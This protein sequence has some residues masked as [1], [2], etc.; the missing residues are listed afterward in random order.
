MKRSMP[1]LDYAEDLVLTESRQ[2]DCH[3]PLPTRY[4]F[5]HP[6]WR[7]KGLA[8]TARLSLTLTGEQGVK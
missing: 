1:W 3:D 4:K 2:A 8:V 6:G 5:I 7:A